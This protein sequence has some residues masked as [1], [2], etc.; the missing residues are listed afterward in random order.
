MVSHVSLEFL[1][2]MAANGSKLGKPGPAVG[3]PIQ[4]T[5][6]VCGGE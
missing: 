3:T 2:S 4:S 5:G 1:V 6:S